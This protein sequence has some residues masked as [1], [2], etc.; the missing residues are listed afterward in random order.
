MAPSYTPSSLSSTFARH[1]VCW[2][3]SLAGSAIADVSAPR[4]SLVEEEAT[5]VDEMLVP[6][7]SSAVTPSAAISASPRAA[8]PERV[9]AEAVAVGVAVKVIRLIWQGGKLLLVWQAAAVVGLTLMFED[10]VDCLIAS[11]Q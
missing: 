9:A 4:A 5:E 8:G 7:E 3:L 11:M 1:C 6:D 2:V 10:G